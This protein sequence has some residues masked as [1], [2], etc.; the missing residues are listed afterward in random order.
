MQPGT[1]TVAV[2]AGGPSF[3]TATASKTITILEYQP[4]TGTVTANPA[5]LT[6]GDKSTLAANFKGQCGGPISSP[7]FTASEGSVNGDQYDSTG[8]QFDSSTSGEQ[9]KT[10]TITASAS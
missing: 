4:P 7:T 8:V 5:Q 1:Y 6:V 9:H 2:A 10:V 3:N